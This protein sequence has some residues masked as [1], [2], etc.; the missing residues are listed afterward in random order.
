M[1]TT[2]STLSSTFT[3]A[4]LLCM[5]S[6]AQAGEIDATL[7]TNDSQYRSSSQI[8]PRA[9][10]VPIGFSATPKSQYDTQWNR[11]Y[12]ATVTVANY[13]TKNAEAFACLFAYKVLATSD[14]TQYPVGTSGYCGF[15]QFNSGVGVMEMADSS[16]NVA[17]SIPKSVTKIEIYL[18][19][20]RAMSGNWETATGKDLVSTVLEY[21]DMNN[22]LGPKVFEFPTFPKTPLQI[23]R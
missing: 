20:D 12:S 17:F 11:A 9:D 13:G 21:N 15:V 22:V 23:T 5:A 6:G 3:S 8:A 19:V 1:K 14:A 2:L 16:A 7:R 4:L 10:L 18:L